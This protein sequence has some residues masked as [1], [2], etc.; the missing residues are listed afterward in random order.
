MQLLSGLDV[1]TEYV[2]CRDCGLRPFSIAYEMPKT[3][4]EA[5]LCPGSGEGGRVETM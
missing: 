4:V 1:S 3:M 2:S 5:R